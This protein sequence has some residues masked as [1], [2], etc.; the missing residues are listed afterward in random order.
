[1]VPPSPASA[2]TEVVPATGAGAVALADLYEQMLR[3]RRFEELLLQLFS[4]GRLR[5]TVHTCLGQEAIA[6]GLV[7]ALD[8]TRDTVSSNHRG[9]GHF[10]AFQPDLRGLLAEILGRAA[11]V[12]QGLGGSQHL[13][14]PNFYS[15]GILGG[16]A[17]VTA[18]MALA[19]KLDG[20]HG[21]SVVFSG[22]GA[23]AE[24]VVYEALNMAALW[25]LPLLLAVEHNGMAQST[26]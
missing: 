9:H 25:R 21:V 15:N 5:G 1:M 23:M 24:G 26:P 18:G 20:R 22:D 11:G 19:Q 16:M 14:V 12:C 8:P 10:L 6:V 17:P 13:H 3:I 4:Q 7:G 2:A